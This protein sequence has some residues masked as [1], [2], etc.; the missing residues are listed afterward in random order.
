M[1]IYIYKVINIICI[2]IMYIWCWV[3]FWFFF[4]FYFCLDVLFLFLV[5]NST[6]L[7]WLSFQP[8]VIFFLGFFLGYFVC[9]WE[10]I[11]EKEE[12]GGKCGT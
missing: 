10:K 5:F 11:A 7:F 4:Q 6:L 9:L 1:N 12:E 3:L 2:F 8:G